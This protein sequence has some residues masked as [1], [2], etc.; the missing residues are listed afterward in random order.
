M[1]R[2]I[3]TAFAFSLLV[4]GCPG[5]DIPDVPGDPSAPPIPPEAGDVDP[6]YSED[7]ICVPSDAAAGGGGGGS[8]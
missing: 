5:V 3:L 4:A 6:Y 2:A 8:P 7:M 1:L